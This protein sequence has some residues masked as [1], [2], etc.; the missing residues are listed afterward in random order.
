MTVDDSL[1]GGETQAR[2]VRRGFWDKV[3]RTIGIVPFLEDAIAAFYCATDPATPSWVKATLFGALAY[4][5]LPF[6][7]I[8]DFIA[9]LGYTDDLAV[10]LGAIRAV[11]SHVNEEHRARARATLERL[12]G[13]SP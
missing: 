13:G 8:P 10:L 6:D 1:S 11:G 12:R 3:R 4:F 7:A 5:I 9:G 2:S